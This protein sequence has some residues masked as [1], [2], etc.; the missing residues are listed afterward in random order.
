[1][2][3]FNKIIVVILLL[4]LAVASIV[5][6]VNIFV[7]LY[8]IADI[9]DRVVAYF[10]QAN[11]FILALVLFLILAVCLVL[12][13]LEFYRKKKKTASISRDQSGET[14]ITLKT[15][16]NQIKERVSKMENVIDPKVKIVP[17]N[18]GIIINIF[19]ELVKGDNVTQKTE[20][21]RRTATDYA[22]DELGFK[23]LKTNYTATGFQAP[24][25]EKKETP[26]EKQ[27]TH[28]PDDS[29]E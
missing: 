19:S 18:D 4:F 23:V 2:H 15:V 14:T 8:D 10:V 26:A 22:V 5:S 13:V 29:S 9:A 25:Q 20:D 16:S 21:I 3:I 11:Q 17:K 28:A 7:G 24:K 27:S 12:L 1:M 6:I